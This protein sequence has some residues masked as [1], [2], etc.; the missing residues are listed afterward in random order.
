MGSYRA[1]FSRERGTCSGHPGPASKIVI[2]LDAKCGGLEFGCWVGRVESG[3]VSLSGYPYCWLEMGSPLNTVAFLSTI[4]FSLESPS[5][6]WHLF[7]QCS[8]YSKVPYV[9]AVAVP[10]GPVVGR[11]GHS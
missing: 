5:C 9:G 11:V 6:C 8:Q 3:A 2:T 4:A 7:R 10:D 1:T